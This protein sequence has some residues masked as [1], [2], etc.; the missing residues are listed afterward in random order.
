MLQLVRE[1]IGAVESLKP[2]V[3]VQRLPK[4]RSG[5]ILRKFIR[6]ITHGAEYQI[7]STIDDP[8]IFS[9]IT[10]A[11]RVIGYAKKQYIY[12]TNNIRCDFKEVL[13]LLFK[14]SNKWAI[15]RLK[16]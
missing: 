12:L 16:T 5:K 6:S 15:I 9:E 4:T 7:P 8:E 14:K 2:V 10:Q 1:K 13:S 11:L 3:V